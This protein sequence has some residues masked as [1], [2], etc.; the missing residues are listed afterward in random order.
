MTS[1]LALVLCATVELN[2]L[3]SLGLDESPEA[4]AVRDA[5]DEPWL[6]LSESEQKDAGE[7]SEHLFRAKEASEPCN[8][9]A[10]PIL[11]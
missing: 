3:E 1:S 11:T 7:F 10:K 2:R 9:P 5:M 4:E 8:T 6:R